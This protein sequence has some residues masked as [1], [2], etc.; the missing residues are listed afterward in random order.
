MQYELFWKIWNTEEIPEDWKYGHD[1]KHPKK[2]NLKECND[3]RGI[4]LLYVPGT[5]LNRI[6]LER[7]KT[8]IDKQ[9]RNEQAGFRS[10]R[11]M[12]H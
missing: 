12:P 11:A 8:E 2:G 9:L 6:L 1:I 4:K 10:D 3:W 5:V 7:M